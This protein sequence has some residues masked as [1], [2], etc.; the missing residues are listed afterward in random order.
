MVRACACAGPVPLA[1]L[2]YA[3]LFLDA[4]LAGGEEEAPAPAGGASAAVAEL[5][6]LYGAHYAGRGLG[7]GGGDGG[8]GVPAPAASARALA[9]EDAAFE[10]LTCL[11]SILEKIVER[12]DLNF[13]GSGGAGGGGGGARL[14]PA[15]AAAVSG[16]RLVVPL[17]TPSMLQYPRTTSAYLRVVSRLVESQPLQV[18]ALDAPTFG[19]FLASLQWGLA[20]A[21]GPLACECARALGSLLAFHAAC[22]VRGFSAPAR[23]GGPPQRLPGLSAQ[24]QQAPQLLA[25][26][27]RALLAALLGPLPPPPELLPAAGEALLPLM[28]CDAPGWQA[29]VRALLAAQEAARPGESQAR[30]A[31]EFNALT[32]AAQTAAAA[33]AA[34][35]GSQHGTSPAAARIANAAAKTERRRFNDAVESWVR[36]VRGL[37][38]VK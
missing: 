21:D 38:T 27:L 12:E 29:A 6:A 4:D 11:L 24:L 25:A 15:S 5:F 3:L 16:L 22:A 8:G 14:S 33:V 28:A 19:S 32:A 37:L 18:A 23:G 10:D 30:L 13:A 34:A 35:A 17:M 1:L 26:T 7:G 20:G 9:E 36:A 2:R 31:A